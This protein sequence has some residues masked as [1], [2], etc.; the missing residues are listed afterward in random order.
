MI[1]YRDTTHLVRKGHEGWL[2]VNST[3]FHTGVP[4]NVLFKWGHNMQSDGLCKKELLTAYLTDSQQNRSNLV[5]DDHDETSYKISFTPEK[6]GL[7]QPFVVVDGTLTVTVDG[8][9]LLVPKN[10]CEFPLEAMAFTHYAK[11]VVPVGHDLEGELQAQGNTLELVPLYWKPWRAGDTISLRVDLKGTPAAE[12]E[13][14]LIYGE[15]EKNEE[16][17]LKDTDE[18]GI[19]AFTFEKPGHYLAMVR[20][21]DSKDVKE[22]FYDRRNYT[23]T[24]FMLV[25]K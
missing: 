22:G 25:T 11:A 5:V 4:A 20:Y 9:Y 23:A 8:K 14:A 7:Y 3:H 12:T 17:V 1:K 19:V 18:N 15:A 24:L 2:A 16:P 6:E 21:V 13:V 10:D